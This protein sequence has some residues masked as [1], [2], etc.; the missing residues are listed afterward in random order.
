MKKL[1]V[2]IKLSFFFMVTL[3]YC[4]LG[5]EYTVHAITNGQLDDDDKYP[6]VGAVN[7][8]VN[9]CSGSLI[10]QQFL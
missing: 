9:M 4:V 1:F 5:T 7:N 10:S 6:Y 2:F 8:G 3:G